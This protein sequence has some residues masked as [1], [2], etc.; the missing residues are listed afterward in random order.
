MVKEEIN[1]IINICTIVITSFILI[2]NYI[3]FIIHIRQSILRKGYFVIIFIQ[4]ILESFINISL[5]S[6]SISSLNK[7]NDGE[8]SYLFIPVLF[9]D[10]C[11]NLDI[12]YN[13]ISLFNLTYEKN[14]NKDED[15]LEYNIYDNDDIPKDKVI[16]IEKHLFIKEHITSILFSLIHSVIYYFLIKDEKNNKYLWYFY[17]LS[18]NNKNLSYILLFVFN[19]I[20]FILSFNYCCKKENLYSSNKLKNYSIYCF[21]SSIISFIYPIKLIYCTIVGN[22]LNKEKEDILIYIFCPITLLYLLITC[23]FRL[24]CYYVQFIL[25]NKKNNFCY[26]LLS[27][28]KIIFFCC[29]K[30][31][32]LNFADLNSNYIYHSLCYQSDLENQSNKRQIGSNISD[33]NDTINISLS[34]EKSSIL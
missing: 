8:P 2:I 21:V 10:F 7:K 33:S 4:I 15:L 11:Y 3:I 19:I 24:N 9:F 28:I 16:K 5:L 20:F 22:K 26:K 29:G 14:D 6:I 1:F 25:G 32:E 12:L 23:I 27:A 31:P 18:I 13:I 30:M 17:F 34:E